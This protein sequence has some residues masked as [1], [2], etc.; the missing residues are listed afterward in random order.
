MAYKWNNFSFETFA[1]AANAWLDWWSTKRAGCPTMAEN[2]TIW[3]NAVTPEEWKKDALT[4]IEAYHCGRC[5]SFIL[6][7]HQT[8]VERLLEDIKIAP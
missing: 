7:Q 8:V 5:G 2:L 4:H 3:I 6:K 1:E